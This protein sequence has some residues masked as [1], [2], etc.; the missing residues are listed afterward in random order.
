[1]ARTYFIH[2]ICDDHSKNAKLPVCSVGRGRLTL[3]GEGRSFGE[4]ILENIKIFR[5]GERAREMK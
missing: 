5:V 3:T 2:I 4:I 1:M